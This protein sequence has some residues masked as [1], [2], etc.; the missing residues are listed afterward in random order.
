VHAALGLAQIE[1]LE[2]F[3]DDKRRTAAFYRDTLGAVAGIRL[4]VEAPWARSTYWMASVL[5]DEERCPD[6]RAL[7][8]D[9][10]AAGIGARPLWRPLHLQPPLRDAQRGDVA[11]AERLWARGLSLPCSVGI[12]EE[13]RRQVVAALLARLAR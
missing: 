8:R 4:F 6:V 12:T 9:L 10:N 3:V 13:E 7:I 2:G 1:Q 11:V 5:V